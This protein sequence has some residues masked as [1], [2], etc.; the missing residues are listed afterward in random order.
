MNIASINN[1]VDATNYVMMECGQPL[2]AFDYAKVRGQ[3]IIVRPGNKG[4]KFT[5]IDHREYELNEQTIT[6]ADAEGAIAIAGIMGGADSEI[7]EQTT[8]VVIE[9]AVF[10]PLAVRRTARRLRLHSPSSYRFER[11]V[12]PN[13]VDWAS[14]RCCLMILE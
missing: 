9:S 5:A 11:R 8:D 12:D 2:H 4:E 3:K 10:T 1:V 7:T 6:I 14:L 13:G